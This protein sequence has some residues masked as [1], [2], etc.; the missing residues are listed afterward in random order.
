MLEFDLVLRFL[1]ARRHAHLYIYVYIIE[2]LLLI[3]II[4]F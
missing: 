1:G 4:A 2:L 3:E